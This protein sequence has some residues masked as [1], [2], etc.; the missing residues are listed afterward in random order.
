MRVRVRVRVNEHGSEQ[1]DEKG[2]RAG[3]VGKAGEWGTGRTVL[4]VV[5]V[6]PTQIGRLDHP[7]G[8]RERRAHA[9]VVDRA[10]KDDSFAGYRDW[11]RNWV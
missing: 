11:V 1:G 9:W 7:G 4:S 5:D 2:G 6:R 8:R 10:G 3:D